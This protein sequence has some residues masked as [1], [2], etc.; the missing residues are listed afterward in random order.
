MV[1]FSRL[2]VIWLPDQALV[3]GTADNVR[4]LLGENIRDSKPLL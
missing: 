1:R 3:E 4:T 2:A